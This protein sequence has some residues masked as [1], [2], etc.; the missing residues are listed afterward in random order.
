MCNPL[1][2]QASFF[3]T[4]DN[5]NRATENF[6]RS[7]NKIHGVNRKAECRGGDDGDLGMRDIL[8]TLGKESQTLP[9]TFHGFR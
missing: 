9:A 2:N 1:I 6:L 8:Q 4:A 7:G 5:L 3:F